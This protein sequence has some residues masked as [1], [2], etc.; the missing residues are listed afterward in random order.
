MTCAI[1]SLILEFALATPEERST[2]WINGPQSSLPLQ[3]FHV[4]SCK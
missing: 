1:V 3:L 4:Y 2:A